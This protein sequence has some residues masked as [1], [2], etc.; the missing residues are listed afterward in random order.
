M[1]RPVW[2]LVPKR[3]APC[4]SSAGT[5]VVIQ[6]QTKGDTSPSTPQT[7]KLLSLGCFLL[8][9]EGGGNQG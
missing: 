5:W 6:L 3:Q 9:P 4:L 2:G 1:T 8:R 7:L